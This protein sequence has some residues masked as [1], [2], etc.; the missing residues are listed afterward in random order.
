MKFIGEYYYIEKGK[1]RSLGSFTL[2]AATF[3][4]A[5]NAFMC[6]PKRP[7]KATGVAVRETR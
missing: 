5:H 1:K 6:N 4:G 3:S 2:T 7:R